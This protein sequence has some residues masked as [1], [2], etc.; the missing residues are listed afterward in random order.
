MTGKDW[1]DIHDWEDWKE[2]G[3][4]GKDWEERYISGKTGKR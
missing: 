1:G 4:T 2:I 3:M